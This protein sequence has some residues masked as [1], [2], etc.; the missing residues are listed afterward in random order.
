MPK[1]ENFKISKNYISDTNTNN[2]ANTEVS[3][4]T[5]ANTDTNTES[6]TNTGTEV[7]TISRNNTKIFSFIKNKLDEFN[8]TY[9]N[10]DILNKHQFLLK[11]FFYNISLDKIKGMLI[12]HGLGSGKSI[13]SISIAFDYINKYKQ[14]IIILMNKSLHQNYLTDIKK[15]LSLKKFS[16]DD[17]NTFINDNFEFFSLNSSNILQKF[18]QIKIKNKLIIIDEAHNL[19]NSVVNGS[20]NL[21]ELYYLL[22]NE[23]DIKILLLTGTPIINTPYEI[24]MCFNLLVNKNYNILPEN[25][26]DF[27]NY[28]ISIDNDELYKLRLDKLGNR[29]V[30]LISYFQYEINE[31]FPLDL[32][33]EIIKCPMTNIQT[34][35]YLIHKN[36]E[37]EKASLVFSK[38]RGKNIG[39]A[40]NIKSGI[41]EY[42][43]K[44]RMLSNYCPL[45]SINNCVKFNKIFNNIKN[46]NNGNNISLIYSQFTNN[47]GIASLVQ[48]FLNNNFLLLNNEFNLTTLKH[49]EFFK[50]TNTTALSEA[51][52]II[53]KKYIAV[54][55]G[56][57]E[58]ENRQKIQNLINDTRNK[59]GD[60]I[61]II[62]VSSTGAEGLNFSNL[63]SIHILEPY[64]NY[65]RILQIK[66]RGIRFKSHTQLKDDEK[67]VKTFVY[68]ST[69]TED[70][71]TTDEEIYDLAINNYLIIQDFL[72]IYKKFSIDCYINYKI[73]C[74]S[75][76][77]NEK[78]LFNENFEIDI[79]ISNPCHSNITSEIDVESIGNNIYKDKHGK[80]YKLVADELI[81]LN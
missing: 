14:K 38:N 29:I 23:N 26:A 25:Y 46:I 48:Y 21:T 6:N 1:F 17:T 10:K 74:A 57:V 39:I 15:F 56:D 62:I 45:D 67:N 34:E 52:K 63:R 20:P 44:T 7:S 73:D 35:Q 3:T 41:G 24:T 18:K 76:N 79:N 59:Y 16:S 33:I 12:Y 55:S 5:G 64:W 32:G 22:R 69:L 75:C 9:D 40:K 28:F 19:F 51:E 27:L 13:S 80:L 50:T 47:Y 71:K 37:I 49:E 68:L 65:S 54:I 42:K 77:V 2:C 66:G 30:G 4:D 36:M 70:V 11:Q 60:I 61:S 81:K 72:N 31:D 58:F 78:Q 43:I 53:N 8:N